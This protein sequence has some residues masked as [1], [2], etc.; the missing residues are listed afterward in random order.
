MEQTQ[1]GNIQ[2]KKSAEIPCRYDLSCKNPNCKYK[3]SYPRVTQTPSTIPCKHFE[4]GNCRDGAK[5]RFLHVPRPPVPPH[6]LKSP[7]AIKSPPVEMID[8]Q[9]LRE[10]A[11]K[12][13][14][15]KR[16]TQSP[17]PKK[18]VLKRKEAKKQ[19]QEPGD[20]V[21]VQGTQ[22][23]PIL[24]EDVNKGKEAPVEK[25]EIIPAPV[26]K[27]AKKEE[28]M[29]TQKE[30]KDVENIQ[31]EGTDNATKSA[32]QSVPLTAEKVEI[33]PNPEEVPANLSSSPANLANPDAKDEES[34]EEP[35]NSLMAMI[36]EEKSDED[37][38]SRKRARVE[39]PTEKAETHSSKREKLEQPEEGE[40]QFVNIPAP[41]TKYI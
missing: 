10:L 7:P 21:V 38:S 18:F 28:E 36:D 12:S 11:M 16:A 15:A 23:A 17:A 32:P 8:E 20:K 1:T 27:E 6:S 19:Q 34:K 24:V 4:Q 30:A 14:E 22:N 40:V 13:V 5:C 25:S 2:K 35:K 33:L 39:Q 26:A 31:N 3:H 41:G 37:R 9:I 29:T